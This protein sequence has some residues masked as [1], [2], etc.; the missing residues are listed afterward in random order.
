L[1]SQK[2]SIKFSSTRFESSK[3]AFPRLTYLDFKSIEKFFLKFEDIV[4]KPT[5]LLKD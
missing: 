2:T 5:K 3:R 4:E 1:G